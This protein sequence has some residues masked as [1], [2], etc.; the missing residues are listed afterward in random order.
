METDKTLENSSLDADEKYLIALLAS[1]INGT[2]APKPDSQVDLHRVYV[3]ADKHRV[4]NTAAYAVLQLEG[5]D[6]AAREAFKKQQFKGIARQTAQELEISI[7]SDA[8]TESSIQFSFLKGINISRLYP[9]PDMR[10]M[11]DADV[12]VEPEN[13]E[14][15]SD[16]L[17]K[18]GYEPADKTDPKDIGF[19]K[20]PYML[21]ELHKQ[22]TYE[23]NA[24]YSYLEDMRKRFV[25]ADEGGCRLKMTDE[26]LFVYMTAHAASHYSRGGTGIRAVM[27]DY[28]FRKKLFASLEASSIRQKLSD[29]GLLRFSENLEAL[30]SMWFD[31]AP[32]DDFIKVMGAFILKSGVYGTAEFSVLSSLSSKGEGEA[33]KSVYIRERLFPPLK[34]MKVRYPVLQKLPLLLPLMWAV[35][36]LASVFSSGKNREEL[37]RL[38][39]ADAGKIDKM[40]D[41]LKKSGI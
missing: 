31:D 8:L 16:I 15:A 35:R 27:D 38:S 37:R 11:L 18:L 33:S 21:L 20:P 17:K 19:K 13:I 26:D 10:F 39:D 6:A 7:I 25:F 32:G 3:M 5:L 23:E 12:L 30:G 1:A 28:L 36:I 34:L 24:F 29:A 2:P 9:T 4:A 14:K 22:L 41:F 40:A